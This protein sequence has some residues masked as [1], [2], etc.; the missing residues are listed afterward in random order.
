MAVT[1]TVIGCFYYLVYDDDPSNQFFLSLCNSSR[2][3]LC[4]IS[5]TTKSTRAPALH[6]VKTL[7]LP[8]NTKIRS[9]PAYSRKKNDPSSLA[10]YHAII[11]SFV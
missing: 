8:I 6:V 9:S 4:N 10:L 11:L 1:D 3:L 7:F 2:T 5:C